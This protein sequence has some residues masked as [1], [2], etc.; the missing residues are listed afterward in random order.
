MI[1]DNHLRAITR[2]LQLPK[3]LILFLALTTGSLAVWPIVNYLRGSPNDYAKYFSVGQTV[4][5]GGDIYQLRD[6]GEFRFMYPP[7]AAVLFAIPSFFGELSLIVVLVVLYSI[8]WTASVIL[9]I[10]LI[11]GTTAHASP[12]LYLIPGICCLPYVAE[13]FILGQPNLLLLALMLGAFACMRKRKDWIAGALL[14]LAAAIKAFPILAIGYLVYRRYWKTTISTLGFL[15]LFLIALPAPFRGFE[16]NLVDLSTWTR[17]MTRYETESIA[18][19]KQRGLSWANHSLV[20]V[21]HRLLRP[22]NAHRKRDETLFVNIAD[23]DF[24]TVTAVVAII[25]AGLCLFFIACMPPYHMR[26][27]RSDALEYAILLLLILIFTPLAFTYFFVWLLYPVAA[28]LDGVL[29]TRP[30]SPERFRAWVWFWASLLPLTFTIPIAAF[31]P[32]MAS[33]STLFTCLLLLAGLG[34]HLRG[35]GRRTSVG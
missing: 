25:G 27:A 19:R 2:N 30:A 34:W 8:A 35:E 6:G 24:K 18:Q 26:T 28:A 17:G 14:A 11:T 29:N 5:A 32:V 3:A 23:L 13:N 10:Y 7:P 12:L 4:I 21:A 9:S 16:R 15:V 20:A 31:R 1:L 33:G 22:V